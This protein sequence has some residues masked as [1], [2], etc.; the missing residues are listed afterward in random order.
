[1]NPDTTIVAPAT[2][3]GY[4][5][6]AVVRLSGKDSCNILSG[7]SNKTL[8]DRVA[9]HIRISD[10]SGVDIDD[11]VV[12][13]FRSPASYTGEDVVEISCHGNPLIVQ[14][15]VS[16]C[17]ELGAKPAEP[18]EFT[19]RAFIN[20][21]LD[22]VQSESVQALIASESLE[23]ATLNLKLLKG[24]LSKKFESVKNALVSAL[25]TIEF[26]LDISEE[27]L[28]PNLNSDLI[29]GLS[30]LS[31][32]LDRLSDS[33]HAGRLL[34]SGAT[35]VLLGKPNAGKS[36]L[37]NAL[38][39]YERAITH[40]S[41]GTTRDPVDVSIFID[42]V[43]INL[44][45]TAGIRDTAESVEAEGVSR[46]YTYA[47]RADCILNIIDSTEAFSGVSVENPFYSFNCPVINVYNKIDAV[48]NR[49]L[50]EI[51]RGEHEGVFVSALKGR[52][53]NSLTSRLKDLLGIQPILSSE[54]ALTTARQY[55]AVISSSGFVKNSLDLLES[56]LPSYELLSFELREALS[57]VDVLLGKT[58]P[59][60][61]LNSIFSSFCVGK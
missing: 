4:G 21:K 34:T 15:I 25:S 41:P 55:D 28:Q 47:H 17:V 45:D 8:S 50:D 2:P 39:G 44:V 43:S 22:L 52:G 5:G 24:D 18:G 14:K 6:I 27:E 7:L 59:D 30:K 36:T 40:A 35:V 42:G 20:G 26:E 51:K 19:R 37:L 13:Y 9:T 61:I 48:N 10:L 32:D 3:H 56:A 1:M 11:C 12:T 38:V 46:S 49:S 58:T 54:L 53:L 23:S 60:D 16:V 57:C 31:H 29:N 33:Y